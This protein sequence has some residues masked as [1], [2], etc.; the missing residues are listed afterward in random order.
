MPSGDRAAEP[1]G[2]LSSVR[3]SGNRI[4]PGTPSPTSRRTSSTRDGMLCWDTP[5][6]EPIGRGASRPSATK[7]GA[8]RS[9]GARRVWATSR[10]SA[11]VRRRRRRRRAGNPAVGWVLGTVLQ[12]T[13]RPGPSGPVTGPAVTPPAP[14]TTRGHQSVQGVLRGLD[15]HRQARGPRRGTGH[16]SDRHDHRRHAG[17]AEQ[18][19]G[20]FDGRRRREGHRVGRRAASTGA[21]VDGR[22]P[23]SGRPPPRRRASPWPPVP[24]TT[25]SRTRSA[26]TKRARCPPGGAVG[27]PA[28][29]A[30]DTASG[31]H[32]VGGDA[33]HRE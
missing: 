15:R 9:S 2:S 12:P 5:G 10:R 27:E 26:R 6:S 8:T 4:T 14:T 17:H 31:R 24:A 7:S 18:V 21:G 16:R 11:G 33:A 32:Q 13:A 20:A 23:R 3:G 19:D 22:R 1:V 25:T 28:T 30:S 29:S